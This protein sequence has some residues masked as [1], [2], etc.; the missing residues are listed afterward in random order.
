MDKVIR[1]EK[2]DVSPTD[3]QSA[4]Q[5]KLWFRGFS[6]FLSTIEE[7][8]PNKLEVLFLH[9]G[10][11]VSDI[12]EDCVG[13]DAA[14]NKLQSTYIKTPSEVHAR[15]LLSTRSQQVGEDLDTFLHALNR[16]AVDCNF[17]SV[18]A[19]KNREDFIRDSFIRGLKSHT[20]R[21]RLL[22]NLTLDLETAIRQARALESAQ[23][24]CES[25]QA[26]SASVSAVRQDTSE[27][28]EP[29]SAA[30]NS[31]EEVL[32]SLGRPSQETS[33]YVSRPS[34]R[35][36]K[37]YNCGGRRHD[38]SMCPAKE[39]VCHKCSKIG[40]FARACK[41]SLQANSRSSPQTSS[42]SA[43]TLASVCS[44]ANLA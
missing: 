4:K 41:S 11:N 18:S 25:Y 15:H 43:V 42:S 10:T 39:A 20:I 40:H 44:A 5:W 22:E 12:I 30:V 29:S 8:N 36:S 2:F 38:R 13:Y 21:V 23:K 28:T 7:R 32:S 24:R 9:I 6:Y 14:I 26:Q 33:A 17:G 34:G 31:G 27:L 37:C 3:P 19:E 16:L 1:V 35:Q